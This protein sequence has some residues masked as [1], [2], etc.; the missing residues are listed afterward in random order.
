MKKCSVM[1][2][3]A[4]V[5]FVTA[6]SGQAKVDKIANFRAEIASTLP[7]GSGVDEVS[8]WLD[9]RKIDHSGLQTDPSKS[10][11]GKYILAMMPPSRG[12]DPNKPIAATFRFDG[13]GKLTDHTVELA[14]AP[15]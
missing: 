10:G 6:C 14:N 3:L 8:Q 12:E 15:L 5:T 11:D 7:I 4:F 1:I 9:Q 2:A 13:D